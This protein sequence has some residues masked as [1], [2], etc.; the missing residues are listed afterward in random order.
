ML[1]LLC[2]A[3]VGID[4]YFDR[5]KGE[6]FERVRLGASEAEVVQLMGVPDRERPCGG[7]LWWGSDADYRGRNDGRC[8]AEVRYEYALA[9]WGIGYS[10]ERRVVSKYRY[11]SE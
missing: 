7:N 2:L 5:R 11:V 3:A 8:V 10:A 1:P 6:A 9:A 4:H